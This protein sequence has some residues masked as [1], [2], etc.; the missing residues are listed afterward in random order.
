[1]RSVPQPIPWA[2]HSINFF[3]SFLLLAGGVLSFV[4]LREFRRANHCDQGI[5]IAMAAFWLA[6]SLYQI[7]VPMPLPAQLWPLHAVLLGFAVTAVL[8]YVISVLAMR[9]VR[10]TAEMSS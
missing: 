4:A 2:L 9:A 5:L 3:F 6:N 8:V 7:F 10:D 1:M